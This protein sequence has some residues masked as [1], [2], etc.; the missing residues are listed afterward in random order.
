MRG[1]SMAFFLAILLICASGFAADITFDFESGDL[2]GWTATGTAFANQPT[3]GDNSSHRGKPSN[4]QGKFWIGTFENCPKGGTEG[5]IQDDAPTGTLTS[6]PFKLEK[7]FISF[8]IGG[9][10]KPTEEYVAVLS[11]KDNTEICHATG[12]ENEAMHRVAFDAAKFVGQDII[13]KIVD[14]GTS[15]WGHINFDDFQQLDKRPNEAPAAASTKPLAQGLSPND[16]VKAMEVPEGFSVKLVASEP[17]IHQPIAFCFDERGRIWLIECNEYPAPS[18]Q[19]KVGKDRILILEDTDGDGKADKVKVF[20][21]GLHLA[22]GIE[23]GYGGVFVGS[24]SVINGKRTSRL[25]FIPDANHDDVP[26]GEPQELLTGFGIEDTHELLNS[27]NWGPD[28][29]L[30]G[31]HGVFSQANVQGIHFTCCVWRYQP[32]TKKFEIF[33]EGGSNQWGIDWDDTGNCFF[34]ACVIPH[35]YHVIPG[36]LYIRQAGQNSN[37]YAYGALDTIADHRHYTGNQWNDNDRRSSDAIGGGHAHDGAAIYLGD[38]FPEEYRNTILMGNIHGNRVNRDLLVHSKSG[39]VGKHGPDFLRANDKWFRPTGEKLGPDGSIYISDW[40]DKQNCHHNDEKA[41]DRSN[42]RLYKVEYK[43]TKFPG[44]F[45]YTKLSTPELVKLQAER[46]DWKVRQARRILTERKAVDAIPALKEMALTG[47]TQEIQLRG[48]WALYCVGGFDETFAQQTIVSP[49]PF[50]RAWTVRFLGE[51]AKVSDAT[52]SKLTELGAKDPSAEV[53]LQLASSCQKLT[54]NDTLPLLHALIMN[55]DDVNDQNIPLLIWIAYEQRLLKNGPRVAEFVKETGSKSAQLNGQ[56]LPK[57]IRRLTASAEPEHLETCITILAQAPSAEMRRA[58]LDGMSAGLKGRGQVKAPPSWQ[59]LV[60]DISDK[61]DPAA[62]AGLQRLS[63]QFGDAQ[64]LKNTLETAANAKADAGERAES[65]RTLAAVRADG[66]VPVLFGVID[67]KS[68]DDLCREAVRAL[69]VY[70][71]P[72]VAQGM[73]KRWK[74]L[75][76]NIRVDC[77]DALCGRKESALD[78]LN[79]VASGA[80]ARG[81]ITENA[82]RRMRELKIPEV[83]QKIESTWGRVRDRTPSDIQAQIDKMRK[84]VLDGTGDAAAG[85]KVFEKTCMLCH[86]LFGKGAQVGPEL[87]GSGRKD[88]NYLLQNIVDPNAIVGAPYYV[89]MAKMKD[90]RVVTGIIAEQDDKSVTLKRENNA[91]D[92]L[93][94]ADIAKMVE[95]KLSLMPEGI[96]ESLKPQ[97]FRDLIKFLQGDGW[98]K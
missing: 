50:V 26:D 71:S 85:S 47:A 1:H 32:V 43:G 57:I 87:T 19:D 94:R 28:G 51:S 7:P 29:W 16:A 96:H 74:D 75:P 86:T 84:V 64:S 2:K 66:G 46:N 58:V 45:D 3:Q 91:K 9:G 92:V 35:L 79:A 27:F 38:T 89:W 25:L 90:G 42:G 6:A 55:N 88:L 60:S 78:L 80:V 93:Q 54:G 76:P 62:R 22:T 61:L 59:K 20:A 31:C 41:W 98:P 70:G 33:A 15:G 34:T 69:A 39:Y 48:L 52:M 72:D 5:T 14:M 97:E 36:G 11:A 63:V 18:A 23:V 40:Y 13:I 10:N 49:H 53:R 21:E 24:T 95:Q 44:A 68:S 81:D 73:L 65:I 8:L 83:T 67:G 17:E 12:E 37:A 82:V 77:L 56:I 30:Y 4:L